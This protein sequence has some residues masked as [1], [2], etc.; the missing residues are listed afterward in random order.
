MT[1]E[2]PLTK[3]RVALVDDDIFDYLNQWK[4]HLHSN[5]YAVRNK[6]T[7]LGKQ[8]IFMHR[9][10]MQTPAGKETDH[11]NSNKLDN[12]RENLR[13]CTRKQNLHNRKLTA[14]NTSGRKGVSF[15]KLLRKWEAAIRVDGTL[16]RL[17]Y[18]SDI[19]KAARAYDA[20]AKKY[21]GDFAV[22][23]FR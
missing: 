7:L 9:E 16:I 1:K 19:D 2:I 20:A 14:L 18:F 10:I 4:W 12:R 5:G 8:K 15:H 3:G 17:G 6:S 22:T 21:F 23:N 13:V 11:I